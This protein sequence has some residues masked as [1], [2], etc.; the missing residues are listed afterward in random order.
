MKVNE[1]RIGNIIHYVSSEDEYNVITFIDNKGN[2]GV[3][4]I[5]GF[6]S[7]IEEIQG[8]E[9]T[10]E[11]CERLGFV[12]NTKHN[13]FYL[14]TPLEENASLELLWINNN[15]ELSVYDD[16]DVIFCKSIKYVHQLQNLYFAIKGEELKI[17]LNT[18][19]F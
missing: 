12:W 15:I 2:V 18:L 13:I 6:G 4:T 11:W 8:I 10:K 9:L 14:D 3:D 16:E 5:T 7:L 19:K 17:T 1:L